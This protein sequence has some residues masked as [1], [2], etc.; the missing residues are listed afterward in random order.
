MALSFFVSCLGVFVLA[1]A[2][3]TEFVQQLGASDEVFLGV[4]DRERQ[5]F[6]L[7]FFADG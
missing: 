3:L 1:L 6:F 4:K 7:I 2:L 5:F